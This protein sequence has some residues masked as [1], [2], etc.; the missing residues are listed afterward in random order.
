MMSGASRNDQAVEVSG[1]D[2]GYVGVNRQRVTALALVGLLSRSCYD[3]PGA[4]FF[5]PDFG[6]PEL[7]VFVEGTGEEEDGCVLE[8]HGSWPIRGF[9]NPAGER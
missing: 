4:F 9:C 3:G 2:L 7:E 1:L 6:I 5:E 8:R